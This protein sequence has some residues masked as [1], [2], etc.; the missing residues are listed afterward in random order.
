[1]EFK[2][3]PPIFVQLK[4]T[5]LVTLFDRKLQFFKNS[6]TYT[7]FGI[8]ATQNVNGARF[9]RN[10]EWDFLYDFQYVSIMQRFAYWSGFF[11]C[12]DAFIKM[13]ST[14]TILTRVFKLSIAWLDISMCERLDNQFLSEKARPCMFESVKGF[15]TIFYHNL[16]TKIPRL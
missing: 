16:R 3:F 13:L 9:A 6:P 14:R 2:Y 1:M 11:K 15:Y 10:V 8:L 4:L 5:C 12:L 7:I